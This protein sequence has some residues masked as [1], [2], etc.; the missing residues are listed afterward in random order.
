MS[1]YARPGRW[2][3][4]PPLGVKT[5][6]NSSFIGAT[7]T[8]R[9]RYKARGKLLTSGVMAA[10]RETAFGIR[11]YF[12]SKATLER[13]ERMRDDDAMLA[14]AVEKRL[15]KQERRKREKTK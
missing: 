2:L 9:E 11:A 14:A 8:K 12:T 7:M 13:A 15:R 5:G 3:S 6:P 4:G 1:G 10:M